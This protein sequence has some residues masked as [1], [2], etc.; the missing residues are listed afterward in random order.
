MSKAVLKP[1]PF[2][3]SPAE[4]P[5]GMKPISGKTM[6]PQWNI[7]CGMYC[8]TMTRGSRAEVIRDWNTRGGVRPDRT[9]TPSKQAETDEKPPR[10]KPWY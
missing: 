9:M 5:E 8:V 3:H 2:C 4:Q 10:L 6:R 1:C 7:R